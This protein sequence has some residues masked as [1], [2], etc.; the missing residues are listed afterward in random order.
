V[1]AEVVVVAADEAA[2][3]LTAMIITDMAVR[4]LTPHFRYRTHPTKQL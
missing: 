4:H 2:A 1:A 3:T